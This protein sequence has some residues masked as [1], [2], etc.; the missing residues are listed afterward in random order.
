M[1]NSLTGPPPVSQSANE[2][3]MKKALEEFICETVDRITEQ[4]NKN[5]MKKYA[6][7]SFSTVLNVV[8]HFVHTNITVIP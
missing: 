7:V 3:G 6:S 4:R 2:D 5:S 1:I 8:I